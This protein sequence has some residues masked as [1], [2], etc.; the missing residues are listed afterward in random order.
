MLAIKILAAFLAGLMGSMG[1]GG[2]S[3]LIICLT[4]FVGMSQLNAQGINLVFF[5]P[6]ALTALAIHNKNKLINWK[7]ALFVIIGGLIGSII[8][9]FLSKFLDELF[10]KKLF[11]M[12]LLIISIK[13]I[14]GNR[15]KKV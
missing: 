11:G 6:C 12:F 1:L 10:I 3:V 13:E 2:G 8:G 15:F 7:I 4:S 9:V 5:I 14:A